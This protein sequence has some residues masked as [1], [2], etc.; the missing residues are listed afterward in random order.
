MDVEITPEP[1]DEEREAILAALAVGDGAGPDAAGW[2]REALGGLGDGA[3]A[4]DLRGEPG[5]VEP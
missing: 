4:E 1:T 5:V 3:A 2:R